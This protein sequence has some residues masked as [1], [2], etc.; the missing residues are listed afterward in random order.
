MSEANGFR[1]SYNQKSQGGRKILIILLF[2]KVGI[3]DD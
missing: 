3:S 1:G 2:Y